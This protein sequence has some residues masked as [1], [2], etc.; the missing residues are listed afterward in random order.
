MLLTSIHQY[1]FIGTSY[2]LM[3]DIEKVV[4]K[5]SGFLTRAQAEQLL[6][7]GTYAQSKGNVSVKELLNR[8]KAQDNKKPE[9]DAGTKESIVNVKD[10]VYRIF[11]PQPLNVQGKERARRTVIL[12]EEG[13]TIVLN[14]WGKLSDLIDMNAFER[15]D[16]V[17]VGNALFDSAAGKLRTT[18]STII[19]RLSP[20]KMSVLTDYSTV[21]VD[22]RR[23]DII[24][25]LLEI[26][27]IRHVN[28]LGKPGQTAVASCVV[29]DSVNA[30]QAS[31]WGSSAIATTGLRTNDTIK[32]EFCDLR[33]R[34]G[35]LQITANDDSRVVSNGA[36]AKRLAKG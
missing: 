15:G 8:V 3:S 34:E 17:M 31:F 9:A 13:S 26:D 35:R 25:R 1:L 12:G 7:D 22:V 29:T 27:P 33:M 23:T 4:D 6:K 30:V 20:T 18:Q 11:N 21:S 14:L 2:Y 16:T 32:I 24:G 28:R 10:I 36:F 5:F 19:N